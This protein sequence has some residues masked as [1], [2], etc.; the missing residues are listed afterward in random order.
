[1]SPNNNNHHNLPITPRHSKDRGPFV[2]DEDHRRLRY[3]YGVCEKQGKRPYMEDRHVVLG[4][5]GGEAVT[6]YGVFDGH[7]G[8]QAA[9]YCKDNV[10]DALLRSLDFPENPEEAMRDAIL[11]LDDE[12]L[13]KAR[14]ENRDDGTTLVLAMAHKGRI[15]VANV[16]DSRA[17]LVMGNGEAKDLSEDHKPNSDSERKRIEALGGSVIFWGVWRVEGVL[18]V[19]RAIGDRMLKD[20]VTA[21]PDFVHHDVGPDDSFVI[22]ASDGLWDVIDSA[23]AAKICS[24][25]KD[26]QD[27]ADVLASEAYHRGSADNICVLVMDLRT[28]Q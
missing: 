27:A 1:M 24:D 13:A 18:A 22:I 17:V 19:S 28:P 15:S 16:G 7:G 20:Y 9:Q 23:E 25:I 4:M 26:A 8:Q 5:V 12:Y 2:E 21:E 11:A 3:A 6:L 10:G 14:S